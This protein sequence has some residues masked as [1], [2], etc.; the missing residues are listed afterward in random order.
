MAD[1]ELSNEDKVFIRTVFKEMR[2]KTQQY[3]GDRDF[4]LSTHNCLLF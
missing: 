1:R 3:M 4:Q 2:S